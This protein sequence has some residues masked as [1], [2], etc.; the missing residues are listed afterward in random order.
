MADKKTIRPTREQVL[1]L[2]SY[3]A[4]SGN[5]IWA[6]D[7]F[8]MRSGMVA[9]SGNGRGYIRLKIGSERYL[10]HVVAWFLE[11]GLWPQSRIDHR[12]GDGGNNR[13]S[14]L[15]LATQAQNQANKKISSRNKCGLKGVCLDKRRGKYKAEITKG[16]RQKFLGYFATAADAHAAYARAAVEVHGEFARAA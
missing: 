5:F 14:N 8:H 3:D 13:I 7:R 1:S 16:R 9:G 11:T 4:E 15:R 12:D 10:A 6:V 2:F